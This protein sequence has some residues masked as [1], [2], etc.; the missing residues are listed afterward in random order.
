MIEV[1]ALSDRAVREKVLER[2]GAGAKPVLVS[3]V[4]TDRFMRPVPEREPFAGIERR[5]GQLVDQ[6]V[7]ADEGSVEGMWRD[8]IGEL[9][10][11]LYPEDRERAY[12]ASSGYVLIRAGR[13]LAIVKK[14][15]RDADGWYLQDALHR[16]GLAVPAPDPALAPDLKKPRPGATGT[17]RRDADDGQDRNARGGRG[18][19]AGTREH[20]RD[21]RAGGDRTRGTQAHDAHGGRERT[22]TPAAA[23]PKRTAWDVL[24]IPP[25]TPKDDAKKAFR[26]QVALYH[27]D[28]VAHLAPE[29]Q[30]LAE[31]RTRE[32]LEA[33]AEV[34]ASFG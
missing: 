3:Q 11:R 6:L 19:D 5:F 18:H 1:V 2:V 31:Q 21:T 26:A 28:K 23:P 22:S 17:S 10:D 30:Q 33:W 20:G 27:P 4:R 12:A 8:P 32:L 25:G 9:A 13:A 16:A 14:R 29:F 34:E 24:G 7:V 15:N